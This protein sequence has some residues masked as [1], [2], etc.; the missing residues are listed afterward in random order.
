[1]ISNNTPM[2]PET[3]RSFGR[4]I[5]GHEIWL[6]DVFK[7]DREICVY[8][9]YGH[10]MVPDKPM[11]TDYAKPVLYDDNG[12]IGNPDR[13]I[14]KEPHGWKFSFEDKGADVYTLYIDSNSVWI[15]NDEGWHRGGKRDYSNVTYSGAFNMVAKKIISKTDDPGSVM[16]ATLEIMP[17]KA[18]YK[19]GDTAE[20]TILYEEKPLPNTK[21]ITYC[22]AWQDLQPMNTDT[23]GKIRIPVKDKGSYVVIAKYT[24]TTKASDDFDETGFSTTLLVDAE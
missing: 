10:K 19:V 18:K 12:R 22:N 17:S 13:E 7:E 4:Q 24:D 20:F 21:I 3:F 8:A 1:M 14:V 5:Y 11:P 9:L 6:G 16:H 23:E 15:T 2:D